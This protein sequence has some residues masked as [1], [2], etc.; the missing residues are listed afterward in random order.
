[1]NPSRALVLKKI[2]QLWPD[3]DSAE[4][5][6]VLDKYGEEA[7]EREP[8]RVQLGILKL[9]EGQLERLPDLVEMA[10]VDYRD[11]LAYAEYPE[12]ARLSYEEKPKLPQEEIQ[13]IRRRDKEQYLKWLHGEGN[14]KA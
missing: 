11:V 1:M 5:M 14:P 13:A 3:L 6:G 8:G 10:K 9:S 4:I 12:E 7:Y 2:S